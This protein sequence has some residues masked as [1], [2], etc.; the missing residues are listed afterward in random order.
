MAEDIFEFWSKG[1]AP[2]TSSIRG[3]KGF[4]DNPRGRLKVN[5]NDGL[6]DVSLD[7]FE[8]PRWCC[9]IWLR[10]RTLARTPTTWFASSDT[11]D[12]RRGDKALVSLQENEPWFKWWRKKAKPFAD[13]FRDE[14]WQNFSEKVAFLNLGAY[15]RHDN[16]YHDADFI[17]AIPS[18]AVALS[19]AREELFPAARRGDRVVVCMMAQ[20]AWRVDPTW[21][22]SL[23]APELQCGLM[24]LGPARDAA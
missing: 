12:I 14:D 23:F 10:G 6:L 8:P 11:T 18:S 21:T 2:P 9:S 1:I 13:G 19:W 5:L 3:T 7:R 24:V 17:G 15:H 20:R 22:G 4:I 16:R